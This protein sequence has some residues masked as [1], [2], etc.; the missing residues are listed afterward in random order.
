MRCASMLLNQASVTSEHRL[1]VVTIRIEHELGIV[2]WSSLTGRA[3]IGAARFE[4]GCMEC[5]D[6][7]PG[8]RR[9]GRML[10]DRVGMETINPKHRVVKTI[11]NTVNS[12]VF[13]HL[14][15]PAHPECFQRGI[16]E[17]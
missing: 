15:R 10:P 14:Y 6:F 1:H 4:R 8:F 9:E 3:I 11:P 5:I 2:T 16:V 7:G 12:H 17:G 13:R